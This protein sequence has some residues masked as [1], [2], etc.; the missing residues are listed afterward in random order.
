MQIL[1]IAVGKIKEK[2]LNDGIAEYQKRLRPYVKIIIIEIPEEK[3]PGNLSPSQLVLVKRTE[4]ARIMAA[5]PK[6]SQIIA[7]DPNGERWS[8]ENL[9]AHIHEGEIS[10]Q[11]SLCFLIGGDLGLSE[12]VLAKS[13][14]RLSL[15]P[16]TFTHQMVRLI[17]LEQLYR[18]CR[19]NHHEPY[20]K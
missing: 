13:D 3:R 20:H 17:I 7:L 12:L 9:A 19:I 8:S 1:I 11:N 10:G 14:I 18:S 4:G 16:M 6:N 15:S 5:I 2:Y